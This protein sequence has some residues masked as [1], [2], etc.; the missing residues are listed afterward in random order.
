MIEINLSKKL[1]LLDLNTKLSCQNSKIL[2][3]KG[4]SGS[5]KT[6]LLRLLAGLEKPDTGFIINN[7]KIIFDSNNKIN[8]K[9]HKRNIS[10]VF[11]EYTL[12]PHWNIEK[13]ILYTASNKDFAYEL[14]DHFKISHL[15]KRKPKNASGGE[16]QRA[17]M[18]Q[19]MARDPELMLLDEPFSS[20]DP[21]NKQ[22]A[23]ELLNMVKNKISCPIILV[24][25]DEYE[26][27]FLGDIH[28][29]MDNGKIVS[30]SDKKCSYNDLFLRAV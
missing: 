2:S 10:Y 9:P 11:Q 8:I 29:V 16:K 6:T 14:I 7:K 18:A 1:G 3:I 21:K 5:G 24:S 15:K 22:K 4:P 30:K 26:S 27:S 28:C 13:N 20:L 19:A 23:C 25:H 12:F 17:A